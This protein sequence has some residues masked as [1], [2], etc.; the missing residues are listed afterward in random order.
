M[1]ASQ[2]NKKE[3]NNRKCKRKKRTLHTTPAYVSIRNINVASCLHIHFEK[4][5]RYFPEPNTD[6]YT[7]LTTKRC[8]SVGSQ[9]NHKNNEKKNHRCVKY[10]LRLV[11]T[12]RASERATNIQI[13]FNLQE[14]ANAN[15]KL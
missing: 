4:E 11:E 10:E 7:Q 5:N 8:M 14:S 2:K 13:M 6:T 3:N 1:L 9:S 15:R 12:E